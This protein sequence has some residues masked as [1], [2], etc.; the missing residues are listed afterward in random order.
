MSKDTV[1]PIAERAFFEFLCVEIDKGR[2]DKTYLRCGF[3]TSQTQSI[4][5]TL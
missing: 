5:F 3:H 4:G 1:T 2:D